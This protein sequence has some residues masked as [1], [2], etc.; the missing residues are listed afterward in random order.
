MPKKIAIGTNFKG[1]SL[2]K[3]VERLYTDATRHTP[4]DDRWSI[5]RVPRDDPLLISLIETLGSKKAGSVLARLKIVEIPD[6]VDGWE[7]VENSDGEE[8]VVESRPRA[9]C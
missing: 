4:R 9:W 3:E 7:I 1:F 5:Y 8:R 6:D 2:S